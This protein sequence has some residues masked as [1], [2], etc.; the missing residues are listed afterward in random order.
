[1]STQVIRSACRVCHAACGVL[2]HVE[3]G[4]VVKVTGDPQSPVSRGYT[5]PKGRS[6]P[7]LLY[8]PDRVVRPLRRVG[9]P[10]EGRWEAISWDE[11]VSEM[12]ER[13]EEIRSVHGPE[14]FA[15]AHGTGRAYLDLA[16]RFANAFG[17]PNYVVPGHICVVPRSMA[18]VFTT[19]T[20]MPP[21]P[22]YQAAGG[23]LPRCLVLWGTNL[24]DIGG[25]H[26]VCGEDV[27][28]ALR[29]AELRIVIDPRRTPNALRATHWLQLRPGTDGALALAWINVILDESL[30]DESFVAEYTV[31][32]A[33]LREHVIGFT[34]EWAAEI[35]GL[36]ADVIRQ[37]ARAYAT[38][39]PAAIQ[40]GNAVDMGRSSFQT[41]R[42]I[43]I[44]RAITGNLDRPGGDV[45]AVPPA[46]IRFKSQAQNMEMT[47]RLLLPL[48]SAGRAV[49]STP[50]AA[51]A[52]VRWA[53]SCLYPVLDLVKKRAYRRI[54]EKTA[55]RPVGPQLRLFQKVRRARYPLCAVTHPPTFWKALATGDPYQV[56]ALW[57]VGTNPLATASDPRLVEQGLERLDYLVV[58]DFFLTPTA[59]M[60]DLVLPA[61][62]WLE[63]DDV[64]NYMRLW[65]VQPRRRVVRVGDVRDDREVMIELA[66]RLGHEDAFPWP[67]WRAFLEETVAGTGADFEEFCHGGV[68][69]GQMRYEKWKS[70]GFRTRSRKVELFSSDLAAMGVSPLP[71]YRE[72]PISPRS[73]P[74]LLESYPLTLTTGARLRGFFHSEGRQL[75]SLRRLHPEPEAIV[76]PATAAAAGVDEGSWMAIETAHGSVRMKARLSDIVAPDVIS[77]PHGWW[78]PEEPDQGWLRS[79][80]NALFS[81]EAFDPD[82]GS[83][84]L[85]STLCRI[86]PEHA[87]SAAGGVS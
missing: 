25:A 46:G 76:H 17:T 37:A 13:L 86:R 36:P 84:S 15:L 32:F 7:E 64:E 49:D 28:R 16:A 68:L 60:A 80:V 74:D 87:V 43:M 18:S 4:R 72:P 75:P 34:P 9:E 69:S 11:A 44:L 12:A 66:R 21:G 82:V 70:G 79:N 5:C 54:A 56:K 8:H 38:T 30:W 73:R 50:D 40:W 3:E 24:P 31:G 55:Q 27:T 83:E 20:V 61:A 53:K 67:T 77:A 81:A 47:G 6:S 26:G 62:T 33:R 10:G 65:C 48:A 78:F 45:D 14:L 23:V 19:G 59:R 71:V 42:A 51:P 41:A 58:S 29:E 63:Q 22:D 39:R 2:V 1:M 85:R 52:P 35:T 57:A